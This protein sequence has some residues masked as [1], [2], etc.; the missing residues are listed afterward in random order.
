MFIDMNAYYMNCRYDYL[1]LCAAYPN[2]VHGALL[3][4][5]LFNKDNRYFPSLEN[6]LHYM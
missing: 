6:V 5:I 4:G 3:R 2:K 1:M